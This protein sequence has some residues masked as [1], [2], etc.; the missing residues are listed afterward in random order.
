M[1]ELQLMAPVIAA[2]LECADW[3]EPHHLPRYKS[4]INAAGNWDLVTVA[5]FTCSA[6]CGSA[7]GVSSGSAE[8]HLTICEVVEEMVVVVC[9]H[10]CHVK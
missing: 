7:A 5:A 4:G 2:A 1:F 6:S 3:I 9:E 10:E 8:V